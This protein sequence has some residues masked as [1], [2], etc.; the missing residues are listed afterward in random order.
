MFPTSEALFEQLYISSTNFESLNE[1]TKNLFQ[2]RILGLVSY[3]IGATPDKY[4][5]KNM[6]YVNIPMGTYQEKIYEHFEKIEEYKEKIRIKMSRGKV[7]D[8][9][10]TYLAYTR[11][12]CNF[13]FPEIDSKINGE[14]RPRPSQFKVKE[15]DATIIDLGKNLDKKVILKATK[16]EVLQYIKA[17]KTFIDGFIDHANN[18]R[19]KDENNKNGIL[20]DVSKFYKNY[21]GSF[22][23]FLEKEKNKSSLFKLLFECSPKFIYIIFNILK[24]KGTV[25]VYSNYVE[26]EGL[27]LFKVYLRFFGFISI[28]DDKSFN[29]DK[30][31][32]DGKKNNYRYAEYHGGIKT[33]LRRTNKAIFNDKK[34]MHGIN[35]K[36][37]MISPA[38]AEGLNLN[39][40]GQVH[41]IEPYWNEVRIEQVIGRALRYCHHKDLPLNERIVDVFR[42]K[43]V[44]NSGKETTDEKMEN[45]SRKKN[46]LL[47]SF[48]EAVKESAVDCEL[49]KNHNMMG[50]KYKC[51]QFN[52]NSLLETP[53]KPA[54]QKN[55]DYDIKMDNGLNAKNSNIQKIKV[56]KIKAVIKTHDDV[57]SKETLYWLYEKS[58]VVYDYQL[59]YPIGKIS[60]DSDNNFNMLD[61][62]IYIIDVLIQIPK[63]NIY[64]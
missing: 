20:T 34:N 49:F 12:G 63:Y 52:E 16:P 39:N 7:G 10:S 4:A 47:V 60:R 19:K 59:Y 27:Q 1:N 9:M 58:G 53:L 61:N 50:S 48:I 8:D 6:H 24:T 51:F 29:K 44:R 57:Y 2:R 3:Y 13:V 62:E 15:T 26:M 37:I 64:T 22:S 55:L 56:R 42:Y 25:L 21:N 14:T 30:Q 18:L 32:S 43:M 38:G 45:I 28:D 31:T 33:E 54:Y 40:V 17:I 11:Q 23:E 5:Q 46:T 36:I 41:I 35:I